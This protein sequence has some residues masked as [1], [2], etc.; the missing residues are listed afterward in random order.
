MPSTISERKKIRSPVSSTP[1]EMLSKWTRM[2]NP[3]KSCPK[4]P[5]KLDASKQ[6]DVAYD[7]LKQAIKNA[8][9]LIGWDYKA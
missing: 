8:R 3:L 2:L 9:G 6:A 1:L 5:V 4:N 7:F